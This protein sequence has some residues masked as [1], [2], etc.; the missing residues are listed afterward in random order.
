MAITV[1]KFAKDWRF[2]RD[3]TA[4]DHRAAKM[5]FD[6]GDPFLFFPA[7][8]LGHHAL[9]MYL[10]SA[11]IVSGMTVFDP[12]KLKMLS[13]VSL[14]RKDCAWG[15]GLVELARKL[16]GRKPEFSLSREMHPVGYVTLKEPMTVEGGLAIFDP[17][18]TELRY[19]V[20]A[21]KV[22]GLGGEHRILLDSL[23]AELRHARFSWSQIP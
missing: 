18:F 10:K 20:E 16:A 22:Q 17:F 6:C 23:V 5:L 7:A 12:G 8:M 19:P 14:E 9:E 13:G 15:H 1:D 2:W 11:L 21:D 4:I 3:Y